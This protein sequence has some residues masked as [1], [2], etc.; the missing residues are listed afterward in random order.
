MAAPP[1]PIEPG[2]IEIRAQMTV[3]VAILK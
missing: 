1:T 2:E 3:V